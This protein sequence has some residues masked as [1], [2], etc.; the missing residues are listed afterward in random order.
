MNERIGV[1]IT[2]EDVEKR[3]KEMAVHDS[4]VSN[5]PVLNNNFCYLPDIFFLS[6]SDNH[7][8]RTFALHNS[9]Q[10]S[11]SGLYHIHISGGITCVRLQK[12]FPFR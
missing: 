1:L 2:A 12:L 5:L 9:V 8:S 7:F 3:I 10:F 4:S 11:H 6:L